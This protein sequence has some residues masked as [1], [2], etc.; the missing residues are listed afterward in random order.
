MRFRGGPV[1]AVIACLLAGLLF[2]STAEAK[3]I[4]Y[5]GQSSQGKKVGLATNA[6]G[7]AQFFSIRFDA[8]CKHSKISDGIQKF[9]PRFR[10]ADF[11]SFTDGGTIRHHYDDVDTVGKFRTH[12]HGVR[13]G[14]D[15]FRGTFTY[16]ARF[17]ADGEQFNSCRTRTIRWSVHR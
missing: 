17:F 2:A 6:R 15:R 14:R 3:K 4:H 8:R 7:R 16:K 9:V 12:V 10:K 13:V 11:R 1:A 5:K